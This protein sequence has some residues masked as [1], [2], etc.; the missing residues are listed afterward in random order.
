MQIAPPVEQ[1]PKTSQICHQWKPCHGSVAQSV[2][3]PSKV[4]VCC[5]STNLGSKH[6]RDMSSLSLSLSLSLCLSLSLITPQ[7]EVVGK[8]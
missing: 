4:P 6:K 2:E 5:N 8:S 7:H 3:R 1:E